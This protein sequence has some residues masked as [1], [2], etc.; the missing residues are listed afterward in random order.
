[1]SNQNIKIS[2]DK[3][4]NKSDSNNRAELPNVVNSVAKDIPEGVYRTKHK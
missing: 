1:M 3:K 4:S 2:E